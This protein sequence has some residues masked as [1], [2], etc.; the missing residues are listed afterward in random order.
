MRVNTRI[1]ASILPLVVTLGGWKLSIWLNDA[2]GCES[3][4]K[5]PHPCMVF[6]TNIQ[7]G[8][9]FASWWGMLLWVPGLIVSGLLLGKALAEYAPKPWGSRNVN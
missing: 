9:S 4:G 7:Y 8:L 3:V 1:V 2:L 6:G 5:D